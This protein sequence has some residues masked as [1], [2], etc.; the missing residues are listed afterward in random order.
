MPRWTYMYYSC[1]LGHIFDWAAHAS[2][3]AA[4]REA[5]GGHRG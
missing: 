2:A 1:H 4:A 5:S 3:L